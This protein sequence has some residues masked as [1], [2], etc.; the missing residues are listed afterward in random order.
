MKGKNIDINNLT[1]KQFDVILEA[2]IVLKQTNPGKEV[3]LTEKY[4]NY[5]LNILK[6]K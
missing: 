6:N 2:L 1:Q 5:V 3:W 4:V